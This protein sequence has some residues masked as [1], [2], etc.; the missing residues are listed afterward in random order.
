VSG[1]G[2]GTEVIVVG[3]GVIGSSI[4]YHL[5]RAGVRTLLLE[6]RTIAVAASG[7]SAGGTRQQGRDP[8]EL[9]LSM[10]ASARWATLEDELAAD[11][12][13]RRKGH[14]T[15]IEREE[16]RVGL[17][18]AIARQQAAGL[19]IRLVEGAELR[20]IAPALAPH[21]LAGS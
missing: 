4:A 15:V 11:I 20:G 9:A 18:E 13:Y 7:A 6:Q 8:R 19:N 10:R 2:Q 14:L 21:I 1:Q 3:G 5:A 12:H 17:V 16:D